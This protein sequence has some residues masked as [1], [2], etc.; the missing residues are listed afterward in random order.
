MAPNYGLANVPLDMAEASN[1][2]SNENKNFQEDAM[3]NRA[4]TK[5][6]LFIVAP[7]HSQ[8]YYNLRVQDPGQPFGRTFIYLYDLLF[9]QDK[10]EIQLNHNNMKAPWNPQSGF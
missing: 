8:A 7:K 9:T 2:Y 1:T 6:F 3:M 4:L 10:Q 5:R